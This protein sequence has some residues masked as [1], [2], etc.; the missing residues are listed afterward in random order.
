MENLDTSSFIYSYQI[1]TIEYIAFEKALRVVR[2]K[3]KIPAEQSCVRG[4]EEEL[5]IKIIAVDNLLN[6]VGE[7]M[8]IEYNVRMGDPET[9]VVMPRLKSDLVEI[10]EAIANQ[11]LDKITLEIDERAATT[12]M[13]VSGGYP[14][15]YEKGKEIF[16]LE[17]IT[18]SIPFHAGF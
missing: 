1:C 6:D 16:G 5:N 4:A 14:E 7:P 12:I 11:E 18:D 17:N 10:F 9:E 13:V 3:Y 2:D 8:V 15:D